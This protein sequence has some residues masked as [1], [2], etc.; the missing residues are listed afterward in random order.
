MAKIKLY[1]DVRKQRPSGDCPVNVSVFWM[2]DG[3][4][5]RGY[6]T[7]GIYVQPK[8][9]DAAKEQ[10]RRNGANNALLRAY[11]DRIK[12]IIK[13]T[14]SSGQKLNLGRIRSA[15]QGSDVGGNDSKRLLP[16]FR[17]HADGKRA[18]RTREIFMA[19]LAKV[20]AFAG[21]DAADLV[22]NDIT[23][24]WLQQFERW[25]ER[26]MPSPN[27]RAIHLR[28][29]RT[30]MNAAIDDELTSNYPFRKFKIRTEETM[31]RSLT[32]EQ[33][34]QL[35]D[36]PVEE[37][38][39]LYRDMFMLM[40]YLLGINA[41]DLFEA[42]PEQVVNG[43]LEYRR[44]K[45]GKLYSVLIQPEAAAIIEKYR[46]KGWL[47]SIRDRYGSYVDF[48]HRMDRELSRI[49]E[50]KRVGRGGKKVRTPAFPGLSSYWARH[51]WATLAANMDVPYETISAA[52]GHSY[53]SAVTNIYIRYDLKKVDEANR[54]LIDYTFGK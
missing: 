49:G 22:F 10:D 18:P 46:G 45:T 32:V 8:N 24:R 20:E 19:T 28:N 21:E 2:E 7:T 40:F 42:K 30:V 1:L 43:R 51:T 25:M 44:A 54:R 17:D 29:L 11:L 14:I 27:A 6:I 52:L 47:L 41:V 9:W 39:R 33:L 4:K 34:R 12:E 48:L 16:Y 50:V 5:H 35:R 15:L 3:T 26:T 38:Q 36:Y 37:H 31:K 53:G 23:Y 13:E